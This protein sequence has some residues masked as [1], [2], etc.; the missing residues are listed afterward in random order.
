VRLLE[1]RTDPGLSTID[2][3]AIGAGLLAAG[4]TV[5]LVVAGRGGV[6]ADAS[7]VVLNIAVTGATSPGFIT[8]YPCGV[9]K[10]NAANLNYAAGD[11]VPNLVVAKVGAGGKVC[12]FTYGS[13]HLV[14]DV[15]GY[16]PAGASYTALTPGR[17]MDSRVGGVTVDGVAAATGIVA[18][19]SV[20]ELPVAGRGGVPADARAV[21][22]NVAVTGATS[23]G[24]ITVFPCGVTKPT[25][26]NLNYAVG[27]TVP[28]L[29]V[30]KV[31]T[32][33]KVCLFAY[34]ATDLVA[35]VNG[36]F[37]AGSTY[38]PLTPVRL[39]ETR[40]DA[41]LSTIDGQGLGAGLLAAGST[42]QLVVAGRGGVP[43]DAGAVVLNVAV[44]GATSSGFVTVYPCGVD[45]P[46]AANLNYA[47]GDTVPNLVI[48]KVG[49]GGKVCLYAYGATHLVADV[50]GYF[51]ASG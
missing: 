18:G 12:L 7:S 28:N 40:T 10:P 6:P 41:G 36:Y 48:A 15:N 2:G 44:T 8:A 13:T 35:D 43:A 9:T 33:G 49:T 32:G 17:L 26:A 34:G 14:A 27:D 45:R 39:L 46:T 19:G 22:L 29:V 37:P 23:S 51:P 38:A 3:Q 1:T 11:T 30:A 31:G 20:F 16:F 25:A 24:F 4:S 42:V 50:N 5:E 47:A 21:V